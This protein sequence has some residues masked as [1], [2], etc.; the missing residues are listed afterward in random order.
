MAQYV[1]HG[2]AASNGRPSPRCVAGRPSP[3]GEDGEWE[4]DVGRLA[5][6]YAGGGHD[7]PGVGRDKT[8]GADECAQVDGGGDGDGRDRR[9]SGGG[10]DRASPCAGGAIAVARQS[11]A[12]RELE[13]GSRGFLAGRLTDPTSPNPLNCAVGESR[14]RHDA[15]RA[16]TT[17]AGP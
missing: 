4:D 17:K 5:A 12:L 10:A 3:P 8:V 15:A 6:E 14:T 11:G 9:S 7:L 16:P 13:K 2:F 1:P